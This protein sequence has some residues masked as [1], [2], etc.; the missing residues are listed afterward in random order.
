[1]AGVKHFRPQST[2]LERFLYTEHPP[3]RVSRMF[4]INR[5]REG[6]EGDSNEERIPRERNTHPVDSL[7]ARATAFVVCSQTMLV[8][9]RRLV[10]APAKCKP[11]AAGVVHPEAAVILDGQGR[12]VCEGPGGGTTGLLVVQLVRKRVTRSVADRYRFV[13]V[14]RSPFYKS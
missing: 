1:M 11:P 12:V 2:V 5:T 9:E 8:R 14:I 7:D 13:F 3:V 10:L 4:W 6:E